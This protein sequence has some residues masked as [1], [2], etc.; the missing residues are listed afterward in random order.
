M[1]KTVS[2]TRC[3]FLQATKRTFPNTGWVG[4]AG[5]A[6]LTSSRWLAKW[7]W[8]Q[9]SLISGDKSWGESLSGDWCWDFSSTFCSSLTKGLVRSKVTLALGFILDEPFSLFRLLAVAVWD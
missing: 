2:W 3:V 4:F 9:T 7:S 5:T 6:L 1:S 8:V